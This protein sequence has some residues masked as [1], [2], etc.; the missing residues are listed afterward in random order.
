[1]KELAPQVIQSLSFLTVIADIWIVLLI[2]GLVLYFTKR[3]TKSSQI[4][5][6]LRLLGQKAILLS[7]LLSSLAMTGSLYFSDVAGFA[8]CVLC[9]YQR[10]LMYPLPLLLGISMK[11]HDDSIVD[12]GL[13]LSGL[14]TLMAAYHYNL[15]INPNPFAPCATVGYSVSCTENFFMQFGYVTIPMMSLSAFALIFLLLF[16]RKKVK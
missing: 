5:K 10:I 2:V 7:F 14:G 1:M 13:A 6:I 3:I 12:Y 8:P 15:Q 4:T 16:A 9:W 11:K